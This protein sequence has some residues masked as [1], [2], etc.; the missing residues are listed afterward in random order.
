MNYLERYLNTIECDN[1][2]TAYRYNINQMLE[3]INKDINLI[4]YGDL[5]NYK[6]HFSKQ[7]STNSMAQKIRCL[8]SYFDYLYYELEAIDTNPIISKKGLRLKED[9]VK[10]REQTYYTMEDIKELIKQGK[11]PRDKAIIATYAMI[12]LRAS[13]LVNLT[14]EDYE[15]KIAV[16]TTKGSKPREIIFND[17]CQKYINEYLKVRKDSKYNNLFISNQSTPM[18]PTVINRTLKCLAKRADLEGNIHN[19]SIRHTCVSEV[20]KRTDIETA[21][22]FIGHASCSTTMMYMHT[23]NQEVRNVAMAMGL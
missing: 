8:R 17:V 11:N 10:E 20:A 4:T 14:L 16:V 6:E 23:T 1:T 15:A 2:K 5:T 13:E 7:Y 9:K 22:Q 12:G 21:R 19:H 18:K 3:Y